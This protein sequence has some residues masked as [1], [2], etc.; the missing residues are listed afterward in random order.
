MIFKLKDRANDWDFMENA[1][2]SVLSGLENGP[3]HQTNSPGF[4]HISTHNEVVSWEGDYYFATNPRLGHV[5]RSCFPLPA[6]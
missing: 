2:A 5:P 6:M 3:G 1:K 4:A